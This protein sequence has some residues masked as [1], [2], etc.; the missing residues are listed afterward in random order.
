MPNLCDMALPP[1]FDANGRVQVPVAN[2]PQLDALRSIGQGNY[3]SDWADR[4]CRQVDA[5]RTPTVGLSEAVAWFA[6]AIGLHCE[7]RLPGRT[8]HR[9]E[10]VSVEYGEPLAATTVV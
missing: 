10:R 4:L 6:R 7:I 8:P 3:G 5:G 9:L 2:H 1:L